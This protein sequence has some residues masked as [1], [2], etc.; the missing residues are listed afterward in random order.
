VPPGVPLGTGLLIA[1]EIVTLVP[2]IWG[3]DGP[4]EVVTVV[5]PVPTA[6]ADEVAMSDTPAT[7]STAA[8]PIEITERS[9]L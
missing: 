7:I 1:A 4:A 2:M 6:P 5:V 3:E 9:F 8:A